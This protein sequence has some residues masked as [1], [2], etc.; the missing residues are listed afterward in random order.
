MFPWTLPWQGS[1][2]MN[3][4]AR[5]ERNVHQ[6]SLALWEITEISSHEKA[7]ERCN[8]LEGAKEIEPLVIIPSWRRTPKN[9]RA[10]VWLAT[11][12]PRQRANRSM[13][14]E[15]V[16]DM[17]AGGTSCAICWASAKSCWSKNLTDT[18]NT[19]R[20]CTVEREIGN[21]WDRMA[22]CMQ[23]KVTLFLPLP[24]P[25]MFHWAPE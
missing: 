22:N 8:G 6:K 15:L 12:T 18:H 9:S 2:L 19:Q 16:S 25:V 7:S 14:R 23:V 21:H 5:E 17:W 10:L 11:S 20:A 13:T 24:W 4:N 3:E 1:F